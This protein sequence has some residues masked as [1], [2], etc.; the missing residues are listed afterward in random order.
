ML[1]TVMVDCWNQMNYMLSEP[2]HLLS[3]WY[4]L[5]VFVL[6]IKV[7]QVTGLNEIVEWD[8]KGTNKFTFVGAARFRLSYLIHF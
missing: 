3:S 6:F 2:F 5:E 1:Y 8:M 4:V 7:S